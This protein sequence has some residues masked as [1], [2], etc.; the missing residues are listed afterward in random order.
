MLIVLTGCQWTAGRAG[1]ATEYV[2]SPSSLSHFLF[3]FHSPFCFG[4]SQQHLKCFNRALMASAPNLTSSTLTQTYTLTHCGLEIACWWWK[5]VLNRNKRALIG[6]ME[7]DMSCFSRP[8]L[9]SSFLL[10]TG[11]YDWRP[12]ILLFVFCLLLSLLPS[13]LFSL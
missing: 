11:S 4:I 2:L 10:T 6:L 13:L 1:I 8:Q 12:W 5:K 3:F 7:D 9:T